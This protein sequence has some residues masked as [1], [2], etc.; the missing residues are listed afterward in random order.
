MWQRKIPCSLANWRFPCRLDFVLPNT[1][2]CMEI[3][4]YGVE[5]ARE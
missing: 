3:F 4:Q 1:M 5:Q 2:T